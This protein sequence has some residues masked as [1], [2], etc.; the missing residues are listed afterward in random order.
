MVNSR[1]AVIGNTNL[2]IMVA[3]TRDLPAP[4]TERIV[5][6]ITMRVGG[7]AGNL[8]IRCAGLGQKTTLVSRVG[9]DASTT[10]LETELCDPNLQ[11]VFI[12][13]DLEPSAITVAVESVGQDRAFLSSM[14][15]MKNMTTVDVPSDVLNARFV[16]LAGYFLLPGLRGQAVTAL[17]ERARTRGAETVLDTG[18]PPQGWTN[19]VCAEVV[20]ALAGVDVFLPN[21]DELLGLTGEAEVRPAA[22][23]LAAQTNTIV[24]VKCGARGAS[25]ATPAGLWIE[26]VALPTAVVDS[27]GAGDGF[28]AAFLIS[29]AGG[30]DLQQSL[31]QA[32]RYA[33]QLVGSTETDRALIQL[34]P[35]IA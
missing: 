1:F 9:N 30:S 13:D 32:V 31:R 8:A 19:D 33:T 3:D 5:P 35:T 20:E 12:R 15:A 7:S 27:T 34:E 18:W 10:L 11:L 24:A 16:V 26:E 29:I 23:Q 6:S 22:L 2:D 4:G 21:E 28:N 25:L 14:G 17:F